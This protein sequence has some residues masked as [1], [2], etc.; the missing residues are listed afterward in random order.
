MLLFAGRGQLDAVPAAHAGADAGARVSHTLA[1]LSPAAPRSAAPGG[2]RAGALVEHGHQVAPSRP[3][4]E[5][6]VSLPQVHAV[7]LAGIV[8]LRVR[9]DVL[10]EQEANSLAH[11]LSVAWRRGE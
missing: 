1:A 4:F 7:E 2:E 8:P 9:L 3:E 6:W 10:C 11:L 5:V